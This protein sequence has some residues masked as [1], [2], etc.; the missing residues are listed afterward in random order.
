[1]GSRISTKL[2][3][4]YLKVVAASRGDLN[5]AIILAGKQSWTDREAIV[6]VLRQQVDA[7]GTSDLSG[8]PVGISFLAAL[9]PRSILSRLT[10]QRLPLRTRVLAFGSASTGF[11]IDEGSAAPVTSSDLAGTMIIPQKTAAVTVLT[12]EL[13]RNSNFVG[14]RLIAEDLAGALGAAEDQILMDPM[15]PGSLL[16]D[17]P[18]IPSTGST[19]AAIDTDLLSAMDRIIALGSTMS[20][21]AWVMSSRTASRMAL[22]RSGGLLAYPGL[23]SLGGLLAGLPVILS[24]AVSGLI[25]LVDQARILTSAEELTSITFSQ[26]ATIEMVDSPVNSS[27]AAVATVQTSVFQTSCVAVRAIVERGWT[28]RPGASTF[29]AGVAY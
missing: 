8:S 18:S 14:E 6:G 22:M 28:T 13:L 23:T 27:T 19:V 7:M 2:S 24:P 29:I 12:L 20:D 26:N 25:A 16:A 11:P 9:R 21:A 15:R 3:G 5:A 10:S 1:M 17:A 4:R